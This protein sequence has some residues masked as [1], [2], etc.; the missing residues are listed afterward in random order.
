[1]NRF[2]SGPN[3]S[4]KSQRELLSIR[5]KNVNDGSLELISVLGQQE[6]NLTRA[7]IPGSIKVL[8]AKCFEKCK[9]IQSFAFESP[10]SVI[11]IDLSAFSFASLQSIEIPRNVEILGSSCFSWCQ[12]LSS[13]SFQSNSSLNRIESHAF[14]WS[15]L[16]SI[17]IPRNVEILGS[18]CFKSC[19]SFTSIS[20]EPNSQ[21][22]RIESEAFLGSS[23]E[24][25]E[26]P[27][28]VEFLG[29]SCFSSCKS[30][31]SISFKPDSRLTQIGSE[32]FASSSLQSIE[33]P[34]NVEILGSLCFF[35]CTSLP[36]ISFE[37]NSRLNRIESYAFTCSSIQSIEIPRNLRLL[38][39]SAFVAM[40]SKCVS[41]E[42]GHERFAI[43]NE[44]LLDVIDH[45]LIRDFSSYSCVAIY[46]D[47]EIL[48]SSCFSSSRSL[49]SILFQSNSRLVRIES[50]AFSFSSLQSIEI[51]RNVEILGASCFADCKA[52]LSISFESKSRLKRIETGALQ[53]LFCSIVIPSTILFIDCDATSDPL[54]I[55]MTDA[56]SCPEYSRW[57]ELRSSGMAVDFRRICRFGSG[58]VSISDC[59]LDL[60]GFKAGSLLNENNTISTQISNGCEDGLRIHVKSI[61]LPA[62]VCPDLLERI[63]ENLM[64]FRHPCIARAIGVVFSSPLKSVTIA[65]IQ[66]SDRSLSEIISTA[67]EWW[68]PTAKAKAIVGLVLGLRFAHSFGLLHGHLTA[69]NIVVNEDGLIQITDFCMNDLG[70]LD[71]LAG[72]KADIEGFSG[73]SWTPKADVQAFAELLLKVVVG[74]SGEQNGSGPSV[75]PFVSEI[76]KRGHSADSKAAMSFVGIFKILKQNNFTIMEG[77]DSEEVSN[78]VNWIELSEALIN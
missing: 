78:F 54:Q 16:E 6:S 23:L 21:L 15:S 50:H 53:R 46:R 18:L 49:S 71:G 55:S 72:G 8:S 9:D 20:F 4:I 74:D 52:L 42:A 73:E 31:A 14:E 59:S 48:G 12:S 36:F 45:R 33:I 29:S 5:R 68:T 66:S 63:V 67:P 70:S 10:S 61:Q 22:K 69:N 2:S 7:W 17:T 43:E 24:S 51:P 39:G 77:V 47:I 57:K 64:N 62:T 60:S 76:I 35:R 26:I 58:L 38:D 56:D 65:E 75:V 40:N 34:R 25:I 27:R 41:I 3:K 11:R 32:A 1:M 30:L 19:N 37:P 13:I 28:N 44:I